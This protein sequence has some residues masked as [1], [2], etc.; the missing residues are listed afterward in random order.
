M[1]GKSIGQKYI[2]KS[3]KQK[4]LIL[5]EVCETRRAYLFQIQFFRRSLNVI[6]RLFDRITA[7]I[8]LKR[9]EYEL[10]LNFTKKDKTAN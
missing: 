10:Q 6:F 7:I 1:R 8:R 4:H 3:G 5:Y 2:E 9:D